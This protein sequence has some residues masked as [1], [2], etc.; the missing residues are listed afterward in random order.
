MKNWNLANG[1]P[2]HPIHPVP[3]VESGHLR[4]EMHM[5]HFTS[6]STRFW[7]RIVGAS[8][9]A[10]EVENVNIDILPQK[11]LETISIDLCPKLPQC[12]DDSSP[13]PV[14]SL[15]Q[16]KWGTHICFLTRHLA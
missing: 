8:T 12:L 7:C 3:M 1:H 10:Q 6:D 4:N 9:L 13:Q 2:V 11:M 16:S 14:E 15:G 5:C